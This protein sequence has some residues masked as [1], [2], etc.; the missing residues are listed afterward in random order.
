MA[1]EITHLLAEVG[2]GN[3]AALSRLAALVYDELHQIAARS[4]GR[5]RQDNTLQATVL[6]HEAYT[7]I[8]IQ[9]ERTWLNRAHFFAVSAQ[10]MRRILID[11]ARARNTIK[12]G[13]GEL[14]L[15]IDDV[16]A[17]SDDHCEELLIIDQAL[18]RL[19]QWD[20]RLCR[21]VELKFFGGL[22]DEEIGEVLGISP[23]T[24]KRDWKVAKAWLRGELSARR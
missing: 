12:R 17:V 1:G 19:S 21:I 10:L 13:G 20:D 22:T 11:H 23:R 7:R 3:Q 5:E 18:T 16:V 24:V 9:Q 4:M 2:S 14:T 6:V 15:R 8:V